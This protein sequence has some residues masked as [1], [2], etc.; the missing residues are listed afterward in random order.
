MAAPLLAL[1][2]ELDVGGLLVARSLSEAEERV[3]VA[4]AR[5]VLLEGGR[6]EARAAGGPV[7]LRRR[8]GAEHL[9]A[10]PA[11]PLPVAVSGDRVRA[12][13]LLHAV[14]A[15]RKHVLAPVLAEVLEALESDVPLAV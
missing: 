8:R 1:L 2:L 9:H 13:D 4:R 5:L 7:L 12:D 14:G 10:D 3:G 6:V 11:P 15:S